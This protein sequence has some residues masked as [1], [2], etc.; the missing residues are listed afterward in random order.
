MTES[1][2]QQ[3][4]IYWFNMQYPDKIIFAIPN[5]TWLPMQD[6]RKKMFYLNLRMN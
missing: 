4:V 2:E 1:T 6:A 3:Q 5:S